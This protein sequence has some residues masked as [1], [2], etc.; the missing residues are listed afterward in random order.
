MRRRWSRRPLSPKGKVMQLVLERGAFRFM[1]ADRAKEL[2]DKIAPR[3]T[4]LTHA[5]REMLAEEGIRPFPDY[6]LGEGRL[7]GPWFM[8]RPDQNRALHPSFSDFLSI[9]RIKLTDL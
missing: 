5:D 7:G 6:P 3:L 8:W 9:Y 1:S 2:Y 4:R